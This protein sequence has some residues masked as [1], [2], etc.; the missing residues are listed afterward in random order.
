MSGVSLEFTG[1]DGPI[2]T[3]PRAEKVVGETHRDAVV[4]DH[5]LPDGTV[6]RSRGG[7]RCPAA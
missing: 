1:G 6:P 3:P 7:G 2:L 4:L 5:M